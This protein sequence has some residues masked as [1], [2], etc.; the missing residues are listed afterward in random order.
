[1]RSII[2]IGVLHSIATDRVVSIVYSILH[3]KNILHYIFKRT[4]PHVTICYISRVKYFSRLQTYK[5]IIFIFQFI[6]KQHLKSAKNRREI[7]DV[8]FWQTYIFVWF[9]ITTWLARSVTID[10]GLLHESQHTTM[11]KKSI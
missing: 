8:L 2:F 5:F 1:M 11:I 10:C 3:K 7:R 6:W 9:T 4:R